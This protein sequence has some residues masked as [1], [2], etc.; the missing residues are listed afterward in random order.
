MDKTFKQQIQEI[1]FK[2]LENWE[3]IDAVCLA[4]ERMGER[5]KIDRVARETMSPLRQLKAD[6]EQIRK[7]IANG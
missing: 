4:A 3:V 5:M 1:D 6:Q 2:G 7:E